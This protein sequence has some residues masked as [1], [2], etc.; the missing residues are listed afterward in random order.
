MKNNRINAVSFLKGIGISLNTTALVT[1]IDG[2]MRQPDLVYIMEEYANI[3]VKEM[4]VN[5]EM[6]GESHILNDNID[7][8]FSLLGNEIKIVDYFSESHIN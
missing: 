7:V 4:E 6:P 5:S 8:D 1:I 2:Y 3:K